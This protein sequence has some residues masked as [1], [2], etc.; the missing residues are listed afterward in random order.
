MS[1]WVPPPGTWA[2]QP[3][4]V[5]LLGNAEEPNAS[6]FSKCSPLLALPQA[7]ASKEPNRLLQ[8]D[9]YHAHTLVSVPSTQGLSGSRTPPSQERNSSRYTVDVVAF[10]GG[11]VWCADFCPPP[12]GVP[13]ISLVSATAPAV[14]AAT[15]AEAFAADDS[16]SKAGNADEEYVAVGVH[17][18][19]SATNLTNTALN[20]PGAVTLWALPHGAASAACPKGLPRCVLVLA[21]NGRV[22]WDVRWCPSPGC[23]WPQQQQQLDPSTHTHTRSSGGRS[24][25]HSNNRDAAAGPEGGSDQGNAAAA[26]ATAPISLPV[27]GLLAM[28]LGDGSVVVS[29]VPD[30]AALRTQAA[31]RTHASG[32]A[33]SGGAAAAGA[34]GSGQ[35]PCAAAREEEEGR[36]DHG[37]P[38][39]GTGKEGAAEGSPASPPG[40]PPPPLLHGTAP[41]PPPPV[42]QLLRPAEVLT[43]ER[44]GGSLA[45]CCDWHTPDPRVG[46]PQLLVGCWDGSV[47]LWR[48][49]RGVAAGGGGG[50]GGGAAAGL[51]RTQLLFH[52]PADVLPLQRVLSNPVWDTDFPEEQEEEEERQGGAV[53]VKEEQGQQQQQGRG[54]QSQQQPQQQS[55]SHGGAGGGG[56]R[57][58]SKAAQSAAAAVGCGLGGRSGAAG[59]PA[60]HL[61][62]TAGYTGRIKLW[63]DRDVSAPLLDRILHRSYAH[64]AAWCRRPAALALAQDDGG[65][66]AALLDAAACLTG[67][68]GSAVGGVAFKEARIGCLWSVCYSPALHLL[69]YGGEDGVGA[70]MAWEAQAD[71]RYRRPH[72][73]L[74]GLV[75]DGPHL[76]LLLPSEVG[77]LQLFYPGGLHWRAREAHVQQHRPYNVIPDVRQQLYV[78]RAGYGTPADVRQRRQQWLGVMEQ[79]QQRQQQGRDRR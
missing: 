29:A 78:I 45:S 73:P 19:D 44:L 32:A 39:E 40:T 25:G 11:P 47:A 9:L 48:L 3:C 76:R 4:D 5:A 49:P 22:A 31:Q 17:P 35:Q 14:S 74:G 66:R 6:L 24:S 28:V 58:G 68:D 36:D 67:D 20:G 70:A 18:P 65:L 53:E 16:G 57:G 21:H 42:V 2:V 13:P 10:A 33:G 8:L 77:G 23:I 75:R 41:G 46:P 51:E 50:G 1:A 69:L 7:A 43:R 79:R 27:L 34:G 64:D 15:A 38:M 71:M 56:E 72:V 54:R 30:P 60:G 63:D 37:A 12:R 59:G 55:Q 62:V 52:I 26:A 61:F